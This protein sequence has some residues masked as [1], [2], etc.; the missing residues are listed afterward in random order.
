MKIKGSSHDRKKAVGDNTS[1]NCPKE[2]AEGCEGEP[3]ALG[4]RASGNAADGE[5]AVENNMGRRVAPD[6]ISQKPPKPPPQVDTP[7]SGPRNVGDEGGEHAFLDNDEAGEFGHEHPSMVTG[8]G[9]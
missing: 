1:Q 7:T 2:K 3:N 6:L 9:G 8:H 4:A 5:R